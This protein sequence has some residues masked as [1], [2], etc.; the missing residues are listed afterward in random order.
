MATAFGSTQAQ[1]VLT[2][3]DVNSFLI[4]GRPIANDIFAIETGIDIIWNQSFSLGVSYNGEFG[5]KTYENSFKALA[6]FKF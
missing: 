5:N 2:L 3:R 6:T 1:S 4:S